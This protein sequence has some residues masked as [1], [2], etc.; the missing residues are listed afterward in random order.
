[1]LKRLFDVCLASLLLITLLPVLLLISLLILL[2]SGRPIFFVQT[3]PGLNGEL[4]NLIKFRSMDVCKNCLRANFNSERVTKFGLLLRHT[5]LDELPELINVLKGEMS[6]VGP[7][8]LLLEYLELYSPSQMR[9]HDCRPGI[10][11]WAQINGRNALSWEEKFELDLWYVENQS[12]LVDIRII[13]RTII[14]VLM[15]KNI[16]GSGNESLTKFEGNK[17]V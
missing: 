11:G 9:R 15:Q 10:T 8:P 13:L 7:R 4:F 12:I 2:T 5:S 1:M 6:F 17:T 3:R 14:V 16:N